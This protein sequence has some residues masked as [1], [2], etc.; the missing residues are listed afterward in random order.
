MKV[1]EV[2]GGKGRR[3]GYVPTER[4]N[5]SDGVVEFSPSNL[6]CHSLGSDA[7]APSCSYVITSSFDVLVETRYDIV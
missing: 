2:G 4:K 6:C 5:S 1:V 3:S 7:L